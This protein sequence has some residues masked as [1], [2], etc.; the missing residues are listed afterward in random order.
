M[1]D[2]GMDGLRREYLGAND[3]LT[4]KIIGVF[5]EVYNEL[6][7]GFL[8]SVIGSLCGLRLNR[9]DWM[10]RLSAGAGEFSRKS[11]WGV[12]G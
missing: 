10:C 1:K 8:E 5:Y 9:L 12:S 2:D 6:G 7:F 11:G 3:L 4:E